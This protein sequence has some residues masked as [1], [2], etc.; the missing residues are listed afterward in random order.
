MITVDKIRKNFGKLR[1]LN[2]VSIELLAGKSYALIGP[3][4]SGKTTLIKSILG[5]VLPDSGEII[6]DEENIIRQWKYREKIGYMPQIGHFPDN[7]KIG[8]LFEML[9]NIRKEIQ[10]LDLEL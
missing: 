2:D 9:K 10:N 6:I 4:G 1:A 3:N 7:M 5:L 8:S